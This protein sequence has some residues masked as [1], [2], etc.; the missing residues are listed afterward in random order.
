MKNLLI[1]VTLALAGIF[2]LEACKFDP[3]ES[4]SWN[5]ELLTPI[6][7][8]SVTIGDAIS[9]STLISEDSTGF[10]SVVF[11]DT[12]LRAE[13][14]EF[15][16]IPDTA[17]IQNFDL[18]TFELAPQTI[19]Q[20]I[21][22]A[23]IAR[24][25]AADGNP[26]GSIILANQGGT[27]PFVPDQN[28]FSSGAIQIDAS[29]LFEIAVLDSGELALSLRNELPLGLRN[30]DFLLENTTL[31]TEV[32][33]GSFPEILAG[34]S[35]SAVYDLGGQTIESAL[36]AELTNL[37]IIGST[38]VPIDT[39]DY[40]EVRLTVAGLQAR[41]A[42][43]IFPTQT[44]QQDTTPLTYDFTGDLADLALTKV[45]LE[46]GVIDAT[47]F[48]TIEDTI[49]FTYSLPSTTLNGDIPSISAKLNPAPPMGLSSFNQIED[50]AGYLMD[51]TFDG[52]QT[53]S[54]KQSY[55]IDLIFSGKQVSIDQEDSVFLNYTLRDVKPSY[56]EGYFGTGVDQYSGVVDIEAFQDLEIGSLDLEQP[57]AE[58]ILQNGLGMEMDVSIRALE[59][60]KSNEGFRLG[61]TGAPIASP[62]P[63]DRIILP[64]TFGFTEEVLSFTTAN[65]NLK[66]VI[67]IVPDQISYDV[68]VS[69]NQDAIAANLDNF[70][71]NQSEVRAIFELDLP[72]EGQ[73]ASL[74]LVDTS[75]V[76]FSG[77]DASRIESGTLSLLFEN[78]FPFEAV[79][80][81]TIYDENFV[82]L[83]V[84]LRDQAIA[85][86]VPVSAGGRVETLVESSLSRSF[87]QEELTTWVEQG[88]FVIFRYILDTRPTGTPVKLYADYTLN[89][90]LVGNFNY[91]FNN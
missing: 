48:S 5:S 6:A 59:A 66:E 87:T 36:T 53:N 22:L 38:N 72:L 14:E 76:D 4:L 29:D 55:T 18:S 24:N 91:R 25:L 54:L 17:V 89:G 50:L 70:A 75:E 33:S 45:L 74:V 73:L 9:D 71:T 23:D 68:E 7:K 63:L 20:R 69:Y 30:I 51:L 61:L 15:L 34:D 78:Q 77:T 79:V 62:V 32:A 80:E 12:L 8:S 39:N 64:D 2:L 82:P 52:T 47:L 88:A 26:L 35:A 85:A 49:S 13:L 21:T 42:T 41:E 67:S 46:T 84:L 90:R 10:L 40:I 16:R 31:Q 11:R 3:T 86:G 56:V 83:G 58:L 60:I 43:A 19:I 27:L 65:S 44:V 57:T 37:D 1:T 81:A 28:G